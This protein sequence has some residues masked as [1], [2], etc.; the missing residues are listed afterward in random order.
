MYKTA[1]F[2]AKRGPINIFFSLTCPLG[3]LDVVSKCK[4]CHTYPSLM[5]YTQIWH[6]PCVS[7]LILDPFSSLK[8]YLET[9]TK[10]IHAVF[11]ILVIVLGSTHDICSVH[12][13]KK[14]YHWRKQ[15]FKSFF[16]DFSDPRVSR[17]AISR[18]QNMV[19]LSDMHFLRVF[20]T[21][22]HMNYNFWG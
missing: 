9:K 14:S 19:H 5:L 21:T 18:N 3:C 10:Y 16:C 22:F 8:T 13:F 6:D 1:L 12:M 20:W 7:R 17:V 2:S 15:T 4:T 11:C